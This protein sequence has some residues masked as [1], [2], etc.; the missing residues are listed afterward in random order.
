[1][2]IESHIEAYSY[3]KTIERDLQELSLF[4]D[5]SEANYN[6]SSAQIKKITLASCV[7]IESLLESLVHELEPYIDYKDSELYKRKKDSNESIA[8]NIYNYMNIKG[9]PLD[10]IITIIQF[11]KYKPWKP[12]QGKLAF[13]QAYNSYKHD[14]FQN[15]HEGLKMAI[16]SAAA[17]FT[18]VFFLL[19]GTSFKTYWSTNDF[20]T[21]ATDNEGKPSNLY[22]SGSTPRFT[23]WGRSCSS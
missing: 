2:K 7:G 19:S 15:K 3:Y 16:E 21:I 5:F 4:V 9:Y 20:I 17:L 18:L 13:W 11:Q 14:G 6:T 12:I 1:M 10:H 8:S 23:I 22:S